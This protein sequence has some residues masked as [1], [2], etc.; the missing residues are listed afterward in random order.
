MGLCKR[1]EYGRALE[2][3]RKAEGLCEANDVAKASTINN[4]ACYYRK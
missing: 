2:V 3:L 4:I 1:K